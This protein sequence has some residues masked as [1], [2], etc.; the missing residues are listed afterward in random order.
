MNI[1]SVGLIDL[2][3]EQNLFD[4]FPLNEN[5]TFFTFKIAFNF[6]INWVSQF[7]WMFVH[8]FI[9]LKI[10][11]LQFNQSP[12]DENKICNRIYV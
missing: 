12:A 7:E 1:S 11:G 6:I 8:I 5:L 10:C 2:F 9:M 4:F 3:H